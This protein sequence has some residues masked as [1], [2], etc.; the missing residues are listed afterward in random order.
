MEATDGGGRGA[1]GEWPWEDVNVEDFEPDENGFIRTSLLSRDLVAE[2]T[3]VPSG[4]IF[5][6]V[7]EAPND[8]QWTIAVRPLLPDELPE[9]PLT[10]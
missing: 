2:V 1:A 10:Q 3:E 4:G 5:G 7:V 6:I 8:T 9:D